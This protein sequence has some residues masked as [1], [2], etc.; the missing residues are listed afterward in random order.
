M[1][2]SMRYNATMLQSRLFTKT[3]REGP[4]DEVA[5]NAELLIRAGYV[6]KDMAGV[7][8]YLPLG[9]RVFKNIE[10]IIR[11]EMNA[12]GGQEVCMATLQSPIVWKATGRWDDAV[13]DVWFKTTLKSGDEVG[14]APTHEEPLTNIMKGHIQSYKDLPHYVYQFQNKFRNELRAKSGM[15]RS[16]EFVMKDLYSF[17]TDEASFREFYERCASA[18]MRIFTRVGLGDKTYR[19]Y[20]S[21]G[22]FS[23]F[24]DEFQTVCS[25]GEDTIYIHKEK[26]VGVNKE[27]CTDEV[28]STL[29]L[30]RGE[31]EETKAIEVGN[32]FPLG[33]R[34]S[35]ALGLTY[36]DVKGRAHAPYTGCYG[37]GLGRLMGAIVEVLSD[38]KGIVWPK[39]VAPFQAHLV[40]VSGGNAQVDGEAKRLYELLLEHGIE[41]LYDDRD[42]RAGE[43]FADSDLLG[44]PVRLVVS[45]KTMAE[46]GV[47]VVLRATSSSTLVPESGI[48]QYLKTHV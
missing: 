26:R 43:K 24:S 2:S 7:Y 39:E 1:V 25:T 47:E 16:R 28:L 41:T 45:E 36:K 40:S 30:S 10:N 27:V 8:S 23:K 32:I 9:L 38:S 46:G 44:L 13:L 11:E 33:T 37:I 14:L 29:G 17:N 21:G 48:I 22:S 12:L 34:Y 19:T 42:V 35:E 18:Y 4:K 5:K 6:H 3:R 31:L 20:A 15:M